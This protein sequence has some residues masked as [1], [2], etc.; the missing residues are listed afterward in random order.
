MIL[1][2]PLPLPLLP[3]P[4]TEAESSSVLMYFHSKLCDDCTRVLKEFAIASR[5]LEAEGFSRGVMAHLH[6]HPKLVGKKL[7]VEEFP[8]PCVDCEPCDDMKAP[9]MWLVGESRLL[10]AVRSLA[11]NLMQVH[12]TWCTS[13]V[14]ANATG[15]AKHT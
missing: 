11:D 7:V 8:L 15:N 13:H 6:A 2:L 14:V 9:C 3:F 4:V 10:R 12:V 5:I 1:P